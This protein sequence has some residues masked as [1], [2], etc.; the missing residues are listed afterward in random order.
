MGYLEAKPIIDDL[1][2]DEAI[3]DPNWMGD[4]DATSWADLQI[5]NEADARQGKYHAQFKFKDVAT[6][7]EITLDLVIDQASKE[8]SVSISN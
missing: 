8:S 4:Q 3:T 5:N 6:M 2:T 7:Q 1:V